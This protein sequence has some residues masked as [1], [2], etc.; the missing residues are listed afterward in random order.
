M[1]DVEA[2][3][4]R[5]IIINEGQI[6]EVQERAVGKP[7]HSEIFEKR[8]SD[9]N[10]RIGELANIPQRHYT[11]LIQD[12][13]TL[14]KYGFTIDPSNGSNLIYN[15]HRGF[16]WIDVALGSY[17]GSLVV[18]FFKSEVGFKNF[19]RMGSKQDALNVFLILS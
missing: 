16:I 18:M 15:S 2:L 5:V 13:H 3:C 9:W 12:V 1:K 17:L 7:L 8:D 14:F 6:I 10:K 19:E 11:K 4:Q